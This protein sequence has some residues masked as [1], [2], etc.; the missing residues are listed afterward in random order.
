MT[1]LLEACLQIL[2][3]FKTCSPDSGTL[4]G[5]RLQYDLASVSVTRTSTMQSVPLSG[6]EASPR[7]EKKVPYCTSNI[8][9]YLLCTYYTCYTYVQTVAYLHND[10]RGWEGSG[11][12]GHFE[13]V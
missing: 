4:S 11:R 13:K 6:P 7:M 3:L 2:L 1:T 5:G 8:G 9:T 10:G 12:G